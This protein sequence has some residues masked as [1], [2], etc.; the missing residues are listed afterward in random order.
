MTGQ[1]IDEQTAGVAPL[2]LRLPATSANLGPGFDT[3][4]IALN[5]YLEIHAREADA[6]SINASG[7]NPEVCGSLERNLLLDVYRKT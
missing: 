1:A 6:F 2:Y 3:L 4:A 7:R 5:F